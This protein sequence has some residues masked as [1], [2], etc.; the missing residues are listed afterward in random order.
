VTVT[1]SLGKPLAVAGAAG[2]ALAGAVFVA[3][4]APSSGESSETTIPVEYDSDERRPS[5]GVV[6]TALP[7]DAPVRL[8]A[9]RILG[10]VEFVRAVE[11]THPEMSPEGIVVLS[12][13]VDRAGY[14]V[15]LFRTATAED[16]AELV[17]IQAEVGGGQAWYGSNQPDTTSV[18]YVGDNGVALR[19]GNMD[20]DRPDAHEELVRLAS[21]LASDPAVIEAAAK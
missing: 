19:V 21:Q 7:A 16:Y 11:K 12:S 8:A 1:R 18:Y 2:L 10:G 6:E 9:S 13:V 20:P 5:E 14:E 17:P 15:W 4:G 3:G